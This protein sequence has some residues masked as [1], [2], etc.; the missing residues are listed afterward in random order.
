ML[1][2]H[3]PLKN[4]PNAE[5]YKIWWGRIGQVLTMYKEDIREELNRAIIET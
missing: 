4:R 2:G 3:L 5:L 1:N